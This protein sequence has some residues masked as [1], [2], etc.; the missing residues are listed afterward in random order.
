M[1][2]M[3]LPHPLIAP[4]DEHNRLL[5]DRVRP[6]DWVNPRPARRYN[7]V[8]IGAGTAGLVSAVGAAS[9]GA[10]VAIVERH[11]MGGDCLNF[12]CVPS[13]ALLSAARAARDVRQADRFGV[14]AVGNPRVDFDAVMARMRRLRAGISVH[15]SAERLAGLG[16]DVFLGQARFL[17]RD[18]VEV[19]GRRLTFSRAIIATGSRAAAPPIP[20][21]ADSGHLTNETVF[22]L[23]VLPRR[24]IVIGAGPSGCELAQAFQQF[25]SAVTIVSLD[26]RVLPREDP[27]ASAV[28]HQALARDGVRL[29]LGARIV[30]VDRRPQLSQ[31]V[32]VVFERH[33]RAEEALGDHLLVAIGRT[34]NVE[35]LNLAAAGV[36]ADS[37]GVTV[38]DHLRTTNRRV[39]AA[40]DICSPYK[41][42]HAADA[43]ARVALQNALFFGRKGV[44]RLVIPWC[45]YTAPEV[46]HVG[47]YEDEATRRGADVLTLTRP[48]STVDRAVLDEETEGFA[49]VH[50]ERRSGR[51]LGATLVAARA[52]EMIGE[53]A[54]A[55]TTGATL[56]TLSRTI[57]PYPTQSEVW[58]KLGDGWNHT[59][60]TPRVRVLF[61]ALLRVRR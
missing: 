41:F 56:G 59:R 1:T 34:P 50:V 29:A 13:K 55:M 53:M 49:R 20:G 38:D 35:G 52:G 6:P 47:L 2:V 40:G 10:R 8:V 44:S 31:Q 26:E 15:D 19:D 14:R 25:G 42:T 17:S 51:I 27:D 57:H 12:G 11:L 61:N 5:A 22:S 54:L 3:A 21:L 32:A 4:D 33:G 7:L 46:A 45:T 16:I 36:E 9:L 43:M 30:Q 48:L 24:L 39:F 28:V 18:A 37:S 60:L 58:K 23:T